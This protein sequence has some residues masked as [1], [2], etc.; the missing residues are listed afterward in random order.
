[1]DPFVFRK[2]TR[3]EETQTKGGAIKRSI[4][5]VNSEQDGDSGQGLLPQLDSNGHIPVITTNHEKVTTAHS[6]ER[7]SRRKTVANI[8]HPHL[9]A[10]VSPQ[11][12]PRHP[13]KRAPHLPNH[14]APQLPLNQK[15][16]HHINSPLPHHGHQRSSHQS[17]QR[18][19]HVHTQR[20]PHHHS[21]Q[22]I[23]HHSNQHSH[24]HG[25]HK[26]PHLPNSRAPHLPMH[27]G[28]RPQKKADKT[29]QIDF[30]SESDEYDDV[31]D[32][33]RD[34][35]ME[36]MDVQS[37]SSFQSSPNPVN[38][39]HKGTQIRTGRLQM[40]KPGPKPLWRAHCYG[41]ISSPRP[42]SNSNSS[43][44]P[45]LPMKMPRNSQDTIERTCSSGIDVD[46][47]VSDIHLEPNNYIQRQRRKSNTMYKLTDSEPESYTSS[48]MEVEEAQ[49]N[50]ESLA[51]MSELAEMTITPENTLDCK[52]MD[53]TSD[54]SSTDWDQRSAISI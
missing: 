29:M 10:R 49:V 2:R 20:S 26:A 7:T 34:Y 32:Y 19:P 42:Y 24:Q 52:S 53:F 3:N 12:T 36:D 44:R 35:T 5:V 45:P 4:V 47:M 40:P 37:E 6:H 9:S 22:H 18:L 38:G 8:E 48:D 27:S 28:H 33:S 13:V 21:N 17:N 11:R 39:N 1:M 43:K 30:D 15:P 23:N 50:R 54:D 41:D 25:N 31:M 16:L 46:Y 51:S 14:K